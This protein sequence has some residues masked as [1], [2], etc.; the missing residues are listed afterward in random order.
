MK[1]EIY[2]NHEE[3]SVNN[4]LNSTEKDKIYYLNSIS[5]EFI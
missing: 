5:K 2:A 1:N 3:D 4:I